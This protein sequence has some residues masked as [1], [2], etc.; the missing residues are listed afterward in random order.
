[1]TGCVVG[2]LVATLLSHAEHAHLEAPLSD[3]LLL[4]AQIRSGWTRPTR[5]AIALCEHPVLICLVL[6]LLLLMRRVWRS[7]VARQLW[8]KAPL[9]IK[10]VLELHASVLGA[11]VLFALLAGAGAIMQLSSPPPEAT[12]APMLPVCPAIEHSGR[13]TVGE[14]AAPLLARIFPRGLP[15]VGIRLAGD[16]AAR[17]PICRGPSE[18]DAHGRDPPRDSTVPPRSP[19]TLLRASVAAALGLWPQPVAVGLLIQGGLRIPGSHPQLAL[20]IPGSH[21]PLALRMPGSHLPR[22]T[23]AGIP[24]PPRVTDA[25]I[26]PTPLLLRR[27]AAA[28]HPPQSRAAAAPA[29]LIPQSRASPDPIQQHVSEMGSQAGSAQPATPGVPICVRGR[30]AVE[31]AVGRAP[32]IGG[33]CAVVAGGGVALFGSAASE[34]HHIA[35][36]GGRRPRSQL[37][38]LRSPQ[39]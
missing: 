22:V 32:H 11:F 28:P 8:L 38:S 16:A 23:D 34:P 5:L 39:S 24:P 3:P 2:A 26:P 27:T 12:S 35:T 33:G 10:A 21:P 7:L 20:R 14:R 31:C 15:F 6:L 37:G 18:Q 36:R 25:G 30:A 29:D 9:V 1:M 13:H 17:D 19:L 4:F